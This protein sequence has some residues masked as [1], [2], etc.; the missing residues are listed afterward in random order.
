MMQ[1]DEDLLLEPWI[2]YHA[3]IFGLSNLFVLDNGSFLSSTLKILQDFES[4]GLNVDR[5]YNTP[6]NFDDKG[7]IVGE[8]IKKF[9]DENRYD[10]VFALD[11][12]E[13]VAI[14]SASGVS[15]QRVDILSYLDTFN[16]N[17][18][19]VR[20]G[21]C[22]DNRPG[23]V[24]VFRF[25]PFSKS[26]IPVSEFKSLDHGFHQP[27]A[28]DGQ[29]PVESRFVFIHMHFK[30]YSRV[31]RHARDKLNPFVDV[32]DK[33]AL[34]QF[35]GVGI[36][37]VRYFSISVDEY[38]TDIGDYDY[39]LVHFTGFIDLLRVLMPIEKFLD[40]WCV[41]PI[42]LLERGLGRDIVVLP[43]NFYE[44]AYLAANPDVLKDGI[45]PVLHYCLFGFREGRPL[46]T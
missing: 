1:K 44:H 11:C 29:P 25:V 26:F 33:E 30:P 16:G 35:K 12:D 36:H 8:I 24:D 27:E 37:L 10:A 28:M 3:Y 7:Q 42:S 43:G 41:R 22:L 17:K 20:V 13:F 4:V 45:D 46:V 40:I 19:M 14:T 18:A 21:H 23:F 6:K 5:R 32:D 39:P 34:A 31:Q 2:R 15:C 38:Y 9:K